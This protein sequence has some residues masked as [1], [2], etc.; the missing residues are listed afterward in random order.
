MDQ[1][2]ATGQHV[3]QPDREVARLLGDPR[4]SRVGGDPGQVDP[5]RVEL[6]E[7]EHVQS[8]EEDRLD[9]EKVGRQEM[10]RLRTQEVAPPQAEPLARGIEPR[11]GE[12]TAD[13]GS[14][15][16]D[17]QALELSLDAMDARFRRR[18]C[19]VGRCS[20]SDHFAG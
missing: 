4:R 17:P 5:A 15:D 18:D 6:D 16:L 10:R 13:G 9:G 20:T 1:E 8:P 3:A 11:L 14:G 12:H 19:H 7:D 2:L